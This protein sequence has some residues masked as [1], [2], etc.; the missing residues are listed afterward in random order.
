M[1]LDISPLCLDHNQPMILIQETLHPKRVF[2][3]TYHWFACSVY[4]CNQRYDMKHGYYVMREGT[5]EDATNNNRVQPV[6]FVS[7]WRS[8][9]QRWRTQFGSAQTKRVSRIEAKHERSLLC[10]LSPSHPLLGDY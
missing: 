1:L 2:Q 9:A 3:G 7:T 10:G 8:V 4:G 5:F 6:P